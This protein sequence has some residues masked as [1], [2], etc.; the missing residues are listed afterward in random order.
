MQY[1]HALT[2]DVKGQSMQYM[3]ASAC[4]ITDTGLMHG[5]YCMGSKVSSLS[6][7]YLYSS[8]SKLSNAIEPFGSRRLRFAFCAATELKTT[9][10]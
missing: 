10:V 5:T 3:H 2:C 6:Q 9:L 1:V 4:E 8:Y 7:I